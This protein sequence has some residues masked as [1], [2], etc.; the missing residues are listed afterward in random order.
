MKSRRYNL[1]TFTSDHVLFFSYRWLAWILAGLVIP[2]QTPNHQALYI[3]LLFLAGI[4]NIVA[5]ALAKTYVRIAQRRPP[6]LALDILVG[7]AFVWISGGGVWPFLPYALGSLLLPAL[8][9]HKRGA[10]GAGLFFTALDAALATLINTGTLTNYNQPAIVIL[11][12]LVPPLFVGFWMLMLRMI[13]RIPPS[14]AIS[15]LDQSDQRM[16]NTRE[17]RSPDLSNSRVQHFVDPGRKAE[18]H[19]Q[20]F[21]NTPMIARL[22]AIGPE[23]QES[24]ELRRTILE[25]TSEIDAELPVTLNHLVTNFKRTCGVETHLVLNGVVRQL[26]P[27][28]RSTL[29]RLAQEALINI[30]QHAHAQSA[31]LILRYEQRAITLIIQD[32]GVGLLD[33]TYERPGVHSLRAIHYR[34][35]E[36]DGRLEVFEGENGGVVVRGTLPLDN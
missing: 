12:L 6:V 1:H 11:R 9:L 18:F 26:H 13:G 14:Q 22:T 8:L 2:F 21:A 4:L 27:A 17:G 20:A 25:L 10:L 16:P 23:E 31:S 3:S 32:D 35:N 36:L 33:G 24:Q 28:Q 29:L 15:V 30:Q 5:T 34:L 19:G 7:I